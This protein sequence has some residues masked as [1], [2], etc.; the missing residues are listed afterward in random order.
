MKSSGSLL[1]PRRPPL[2]GWSLMMSS[3]AS[4]RMAARSRCCVSM[5]SKWG[6][7]VRTRCAASSRSV[8]PVPKALRMS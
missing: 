6:S 1:S 7:S 5:S 2:P 8:S 4:M 3:L